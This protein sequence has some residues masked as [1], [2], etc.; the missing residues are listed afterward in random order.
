LEQRRSRTDRRQAFTLLEVLL[1]SAIAVLLMAA[2]YAAMDVQLRHAQAAR[3]V[4]EQGTLA[5]NLLAR[6]SRDIAPTLGPSL[7]SPSGGTGTPA[8][9]TTT[10]TTASPSPSSTAPPSLVGPITVNVG[11]QGDAT[12]LTVSVSRLPLDLASA[13]GDLPVSSDLRRITYWLVEGGDVPLGLARQEVMLVTSDEAT[14][15]PPD[16]PDEAAHVE[17][18]EVKSLAFSYWDG[19]QWLESWDSSAVGE[20]GQSPMGPPQLIAITL[21]ITSPRGVLKLHRHVV[22]LHTANGLPPPTTTTT[23]P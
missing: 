5:R 11:V 16:I 4:V 10:D 3:D 21:G 6:M 2:L 18:E 17:A 20:D 12:R 22:A 8:S 13:T 7:P 9:G 15:L 14:A 19:T 23:T 1:S